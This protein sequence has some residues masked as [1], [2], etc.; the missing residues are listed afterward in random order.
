MV[1]VVF[2]VLFFEKTHFP[3]RKKKMFQQK[4]KKANK[5]TKFWLKKGKIWTKFW[6]YSTYKYNIYIDSCMLYSG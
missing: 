1:I 5:M 6:L 2:L 4:Q 3:F